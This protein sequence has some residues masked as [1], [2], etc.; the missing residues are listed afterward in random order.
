MLFG[1]KQSLV[2]LDIGSH[3]IKVVELE[4]QTNKAQQHVRYDTND[5]SLDFEIAGAE[6]ND[7]KQMWVLQVAAKKGKVLS[8]SDLIRDAGLHQLIDDVDSFAAQNALGANY[9]FDPEEVVA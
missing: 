3:T 4:A 2:G 1:K 9:D 5:V 7:A 8:F 6:P